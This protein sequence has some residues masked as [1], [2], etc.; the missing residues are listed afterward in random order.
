[1]NNKRIHRLWWEEGLHVPYKKRKW[2][3]RV[4]V[5]APESL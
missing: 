4:S 3:L 1:V 2:P 5:G